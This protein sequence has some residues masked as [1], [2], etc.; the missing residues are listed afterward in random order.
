[1]RV[2]QSKLSGWELGKLTPSQANVDQIE[3]ILESINDIDAQDMKKHRVITVAK[4]S[5]TR[6]DKDSIKAFVSGIRQNRENLLPIFPFGRFSFNT[7]KSSPVALALFA[8]CGGFS[9]GFRW[10]GIKIAGYV[11]INPAFGEV[12]ETNFPGVPNLGSDITSITDDSIL[13]WKQRLG[14]VNVLFGGPPCQGFSLTGKRNPKDLRNQLYAYVIRIASLLKPEVI[15]IENV[16]VL[17]TMKA[18]NGYS[19]PAIILDSFKQAGYKCKYKELN[20]QEYGVPQFRR[21]VFFM[22]VRKDLLVEPSFPLPT[23]GPEQR[24]SLFGNLSPSL[25]FRDATGDLEPL[26]SGEKSIIDPLHFAV[27]HPAHVINWLKN[28]PEGQSAHQ[29]LDPSLRPPSGYNTTYKRLRWDAPSSTI[30]T[31]FGMI[32]ASNRVHPRDTR[33]LTIREALRCQTFPDDFQMFGTLSAIRTMIGNA[34]PP[35][36]AKAIGEHIVNV[37]LGHNIPTVEVND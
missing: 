3:R 12:Y 10:A 22:G 18:S 7:A 6:V 21:R 27:T 37:I 34:V 8:G 11:E 32:S 19:M 14:P 35:L 24:K 9:L 26:E 23:H 25:T 15:V 33:S 17:T 36:L 1:M 31:T 29:N 13:G 28:V 2:R 30:G 5:S 16:G 4:Q 20:A